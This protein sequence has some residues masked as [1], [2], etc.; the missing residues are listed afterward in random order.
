[1][2]IAQALQRDNLDIVMAGLLIG[3]YLCVLAEPL[4]QAARS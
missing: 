1:M 3:R 2:N 4:D